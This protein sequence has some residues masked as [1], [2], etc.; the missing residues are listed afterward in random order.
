MARILLIEDDR[1][2]RDMLVEAMVEAGHDVRSACDGKD[3]V[4]QFRK[5]PADLVLTDIVMPDQ[6]GIQTIVELRR[7]FPEVKIIAMSGGG[8][9]GADTYLRLARNLGA[10]VTMAKPFS[11]EALFQVVNGLLSAT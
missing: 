6:E 5:D 3:G 2:F 7:D 1:P 11:L 4:R 8:S 10:D 9:V